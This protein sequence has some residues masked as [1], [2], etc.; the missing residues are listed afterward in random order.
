MKR[1]NLNDVNKSQFQV[2]WLPGFLALLI[3]IL[4]NLAPLAL[5]SNRL[6]PWAYNSVLSGGLLVATL[7]WS[8]TV[9][10]SERRVSLQQVAGSLVLYAMVLVW[11][12][13]QAISLS[14]DGL[15]N[16]IWSLAG[17]VEPSVATHAISINPE[18]SLLACMRLS[19]YASVFLCVFL[20][21]GK[22]ERASFLLWFFVVS[23]CLYA[24]Y[25]LFRYASDWDKI[26]WYSTTGKQLSGPFINRNNAATYFG[27][28]LVCALAMMLKSIGRKTSENHHAAFRFRLLAIFESLSGRTGILFVISATLL[29]ALMLTASRGGIM[30]TLAGCLTLAGLQIVKRGTGPSG[31]FRFAGLGVIA[32]LFLVTLEV[33]GSVLTA[34][35]LSSDLETGGRLD[36]YRMTASAISDNAWVGTGLGTFQDMFPIFRDDILTNGLIWDKAHNDYLELLLG[37][38]VPAAGL[39][40]ICLAVLFVRAL[41]GYFNRRRDSI[42]CG[43]AVSVSAIAILHSLI[44]FSLQIQAIAMAYSMLLALGVAQSRSSRRQT[45]D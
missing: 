38:G 20:L 18:N 24:V 27:F 22:P 4:I 8:L 29:T 1:A 3:G 23:A 26:L 28:G 36:V 40:L 25:G 32:V 45:S 19:T 37:F 33:S 21:A 34:R 12:G 11:A 15:A 13:A 14:P 39:F 7:A 44:D 2:F 43:V 9:P 41:R 17:D 31:A 30:A 6:L 10:A 5:G 42:Y 35:I 16:P